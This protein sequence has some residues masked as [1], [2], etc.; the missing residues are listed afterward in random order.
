MHFLK[1]TQ[2]SVFFVGFLFDKK[3]KEKPDTCSGEASVLLGQA[4]SSRSFGFRLCL[5]VAVILPSGKSYHKQG[6]KTDENNINSSS[7]IHIVKK[8]LL[9]KNFLKNALL[10]KSFRH[11]F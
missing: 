5:F 10:F 4:F 9:S 1:T 7:I 8:H 11:Y 2:N 6:V 3:K